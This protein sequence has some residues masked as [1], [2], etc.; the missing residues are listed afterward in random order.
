MGKLR[1][2][3]I[4]SSIVQARSSKGNASWI[5]SVPGEGTPRVVSHPSRD[6][7]HVIYAR[8]CLFSSVHRTT[9]SFRSISSIIHIQPFPHGYWLHGNGVSIDCSLKRHPWR[10]GKRPR[11][12]SYGHAQR[13]QSSSQPDPS[14]GFTEAW[15]SVHSRS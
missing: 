2:R 9:F 15:R 14:R 3:Q 10:S 13:K 1:T 11:W 7:K 6:E 5:A 8:A 4:L 12:G